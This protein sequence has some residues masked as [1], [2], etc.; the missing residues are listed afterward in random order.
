MNLTDRD[1]IRGLID[2]VGALA[3]RLTGE[4]PDIRLSDDGGHWVW[5]RATA[6]SVRWVAE[7]APTGDDA[8]PRMPAGSIPPSPPKTPGQVAWDLA[9]GD[10]T[11]KDTHLAIADICHRLETIEAVVAATKTAQDNAIRF[12]RLRQCLADLGCPWPEG[13]H[14]PTTIRAWLISLREAERDQ[15]E[16]AV[17]HATDRLYGDGPPSP[18][19]VAAAAIDAIKARRDIIQAAKDAIQPRTP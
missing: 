6:S 10:R 9:R 14:M 7:D 11:V 15:C 8:V 4:V 1:L 2:L 13:C 3:V 19:A 17:H 16:Y 18:S 5:T 12:D